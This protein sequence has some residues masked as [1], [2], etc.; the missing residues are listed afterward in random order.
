ML[1]RLGSYFRSSCISLSECWNY[2]HSPRL[3]LF[4]IMCSWSQ[5]RELELNPG[6]ATQKVNIESQHMQLRHGVEDAWAGEGKD[7]SQ[8]LSMSHRCE[9]PPY[10]ALLWNQVTTFKY[11]WGHLQCTLHKAMTWLPGLA[12]LPDG[13]CSSSLL[14]YVFFSSYSSTTSGCLTVVNLTHLN[15]LPAAGLCHLAH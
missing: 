1:P 12:C 14:G 15:P 6:I 5:S 3:P 4:N 2:S 13:R 11:R 9:L 8:G 7:G 10:R